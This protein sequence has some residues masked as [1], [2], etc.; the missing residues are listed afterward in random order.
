MHHLWFSLWS[1]VIPIVTATLFS[2]QF[3]QSQVEKFCQAY[4]TWEHKTPEKVADRQI[5]VSDEAK[6]ALCYVP[7]TGCTTLKVLLFM[8]L[9]KK[10]IHTPIAP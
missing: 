1:Y 9:S 7:K 4:E 2:I 8:T 10:S 5:L 3:Q 6:T